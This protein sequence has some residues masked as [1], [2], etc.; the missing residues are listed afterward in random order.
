MEKLAVIIALLFVPILIKA[1]MHSEPREC[2]DYE[3]DGYFTVV[4]S[5]PVFLVN[6]GSKNQIS[7]RF[8]NKTDEK[9]L[10]PVYGINYSLIVRLPDAC[11]VDCNAGIITV[12]GPLEPFSKP[13]FFSDDQKPISGKKLICTPQLK[14]T[15]PDQQRL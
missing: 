1:N 10:P 8:K 15:K 11:F 7:I 6:R 13:R 12:I 3:L 5:K 4:N 9:K 2:G 14:S